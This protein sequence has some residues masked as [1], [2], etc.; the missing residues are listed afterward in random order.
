MECL[1]LDKRLLPDCAVNNHHNL[2]GMDFFLKSFHFF[3]EVFFFFVAPSGIH[4]Y[5]FLVTELLQAFVNHFHR[6]FSLHVAIN[7]N[8]NAG[9]QLLK[10]RESAR[11]IRVGT[12]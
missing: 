12:D 7:W 3:D 8:V 6:V 1:R 9:R 10:L 5:D 2:V 4:D 11:A